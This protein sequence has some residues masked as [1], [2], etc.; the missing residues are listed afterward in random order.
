MPLHDSLASSQAVRLP[1]LSST[2]TTEDLQQAYALGAAN[3][4]K[5]LTVVELPFK[6]P[7]NGANFIVKL[8]VGQK[9]NAPPTWTLQRGDGFGGKTLWTG[10][11]EDVGAIHKEIRIN[12]QSIGEGLTSINSELDAK[13]QAKAAAEA[14]QVRRKK[15]ATIP[16]VKLQEPIILGD[17]PTPGRSLPG[18]AIPARSTGEI[19][20][21]P[22]PATLDAFFSPN[23]PPAL[24]AFLCANQPPAINA[25]PPAVPSPAPVAPASK[26]PSAPLPPPI[27]FDKNVLNETHRQ[28]C[29]QTSGLMTFPA[30]VYFLFREFMRFQKCQEP[31]S[32]VI[33]EIAVRKGGRV[34]ALCHDALRIATERL[35]SVCGPLDVGAQLSATEFGF[36]V[37][38]TNGAGALDFAVNAQDA[39]TSEPIVSGADEAVLLAVGAASLP[40]TCSHPEVLVAAARQAKEMTKGTDQQ[41][42]LF[43]AD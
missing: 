27:K 11:S 16:D 3:K 15:T 9:L 43:P 28:L 22:A 14:E 30:F 38:S 24:D 6:N 19:Y 26:R 37:A 4:Y 8:S 17:R 1:K 10:S 36:V 2:P 13:A 39:L 35:R 34:E 23:Y 41:C 29:D 40:D 20:C 18:A 21:G 25:V 42:L 32:V 31:F 12:S 5:G 7:Q 33:V